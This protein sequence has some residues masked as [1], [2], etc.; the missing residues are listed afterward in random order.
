MQACGYFRD[1]G[2]PGS[3]AEQNRNF[4]DYCLGQGYEVSATFSDR[5][6]E[7]SGFLRLIDFISSAPES[8]NDVPGGS[9]EPG[10]KIAVI[11]RRQALGTT[12]EVAAA[13]YFGLKSTGATVVILDAPQ[14]SPWWAQTPAPGGRRRPGSR[15][16]DG[17]RTRALKGHVLGRPPFGYRAAPS[18]RLEPV[19]SEADVV[20]EIFRLY[21]REG[22]GVRLIARRLNQEGTRTRQGNLWTMV[23][24]RD[25]LRNRVYLGNYSRLGV[26]VPRS[27]PGLVSANE[28]QRVQQLLTAR[29]SRTAAR[30]AGQFLLA[31]LLYC[32]VCGN[33]LIG[34]SRKQTW[35]RTDGAVVAA[36]Y[37]YY[38]C[39][40]RTNQGVCSYHTRRARDLELLIKDGLSGG[41]DS[42]IVR[43]SRVGNPQG[44]EAS[45]GRDLAGIEADLRKVDARL[46]RLLGATDLRQPQAQKALEGAGLE[47]IRLEKRRLELASG[48]RARY[49]DNEA[50][51][52][53]R[54]RLASLDREWDSMDFAELRDI[55]VSCIERVDVE[56]DRITITTV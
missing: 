32:A 25:I 22:L 55:L 12:S 35:R 20:R 3:L 9:I 41:C 31:G 14:G 5:G 33:R 26:R 50:Q 34:V 28:F 47:R 46:G 51:L 29:R 7:R 48:I 18:R 16:R 21:N 53:L 23:S 39:Q 30:T 6:Q 2:E 49:A 8:G 44:L 38:Q 36:E 13:S 37:R 11:P 45:T 10:F 24:V 15:V 40:S 17:M 4:L 54:T 52:Y 42:V 43:N 1:L 19:S 56:D 27:H